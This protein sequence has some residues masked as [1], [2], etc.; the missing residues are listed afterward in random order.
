MP[1]E[2]QRTRW[3]MRS[4]NGRRW[5]TDERYTI[6]EMF[7]EYPDPA[8]FTGTGK[9]PLFLCS[10]PISPIHN[11]PLINP[12]PGD[13]GSTPGLYICATHQDHT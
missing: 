6:D 12:K 1:D 13:K 10:T 5:E 2:Q 11:D 3:V 8:N 9:R 4:S 7:A